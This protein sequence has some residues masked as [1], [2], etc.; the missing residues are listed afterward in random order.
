MNRMYLAQQCMPV[1]G[2]NQLITLARLGC[3]CAILLLT[4]TACTF[5][6]GTPNTEITGLV[7][8]DSV[9]LQEQGISK[10]V[11]LPSATVRCNNVSTTTDQNGRYKLS[12]APH[13]TYNCTASAPLY[14][15]QNDQ[16]DLAQGTALILN[17][18]PSTEAVCSGTTVNS[19]HDTE[20]CGLLPLGPG[21]LS[22]TVLSDGSNLPVKNAKVT[23]VLI[24]PAALTSPL[25]SSDGVTATTSTDGSFSFQGMAVGSYT[26]LTFAK[27]V[28]KGRQIVAI[29]PAATNT[30]T[31]KSCSH[32]CHPV[33]FHGG[34]VM[35][36]M[37]A[38]LIF[39]LPRGY[40]FDPGGSDSYYESLIKRFFQDLQ[41][42]KYYRLLTQYWDYQGSI[43]DQV[44]LGG[45]YVDRT[46]YQHCTYSGL[47]CTRSAASYKDPLLDVDIQGEISRALKANP[48]WSAA[49]THEFFVFT[50]NSAQEC[51]GGAPGVDC[52]YTPYPGGFCAYHSAFFDNGSY[53]NPNDGTPPYIYGY[54]PAPAAESPTYGC[55]PQDL[56]LTG[57]A[58]HGDGTPDMAVNFVSHEM[59]ESITDPLYNPIGPPSSGWFNDAAD[60]KN[61]GLGEIGDLCSNDYVQIGADGGNVT[62]LHRD[63]YVVQAEWSNVTNSCS[64]G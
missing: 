47:V 57:V 36:A 25:D 16:L 21:N 26:C 6:L 54:V 17:F 11:P 38:Y 3:L 64:L 50:G 14:R 28:T 18:G 32:D 20:N 2:R 27:G 33:E 8:G 48:S 15:S 59:F 30:T 55:A 4:Q 58:S 51:A 60:A 7:Y 44:A 61:A 40:T 22:G 46:R 41:G 13:P 19:P 23:C 53:I 12:L 24:D 9:S 52:T 62:L 29:A 1:T 37:T 63:H 42:T 5:A 35:R 43:Q 34:P 31:I 39:W 56:N 49:Q 10:A 45:I